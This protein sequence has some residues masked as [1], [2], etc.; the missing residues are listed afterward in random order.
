MSTRRGHGEGSIYYR[1]SDNKWCGVVD[2]GYINGKRKRRVVYGNTRKDVAEKLKAVLRDQQ[3]GL[4]IATERQMVG[5]FLTRWL[6]DVVAPQTRPKT[7]RSY[8]QLA[9]CHITPVLGH[10][11]LTK[12]TAQH[13]QAFLNAKAAAGLAPRSVQR[14]RDVLRNALNQAYRW[15]LVPRNVALLVDSPKVETSEMAAFSPAQVQTFLDT[16][17]GDRLEALYLVAVALGLRQGEVLG[18]RWQDVDLERRTLRVAVA[19]QAVRGTLQLVPPKTTRSSRTL[20][21]PAVVGAALQAQRVRQMEER[22]LAGA[23]WQEHGLIFTTRVGTPIH[24]RN[25][26]RS[27]HAL[28]RRAGLPAVRFHDLRHS[29][30]SMLAAHGVPARVAMDILGHSD[31]RLTQNIYTHV[32]DEAKQ[33]AADVVDRVFNQER[34]RVG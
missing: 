20:P 14:I 30:A 15:Q 10:H 13:V 18:L 28:L 24:P 7:Y 21:L 12:L 22:L 26:V 6:A 5:Q 33:Q 8:E 19:L 2:L 31:I 32:F 11:Q 34:A 4:P 23:R 27:F 17:R 1:E 16:A 29:C 3:Q 9:R 25:L